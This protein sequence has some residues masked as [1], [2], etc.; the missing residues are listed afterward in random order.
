MRVKC[1]SSQFFATLIR[2]C[3]HSLSNVLSKTNQIRNLDAQVDRSHSAQLRPNYIS[4]GSSQLKAGPAQFRLFTL[5]MNQAWDWA[6]LQ[7]DTVGLWLNK[8]PT[9]LNCI[10]SYHKGLYNVQ[11]QYAW[12]LIS[13]ERLFWFWLHVKLLGWFG[14]LVFHFGVLF[15]KKYKQFKT[16]HTW[17]K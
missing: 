9:H 3:S 15:Q 7:K 16:T 1:W 6:Y 8:Y 14:I 13:F 4:V 12:L 11:D 2:F 10:P 17:K 5:F